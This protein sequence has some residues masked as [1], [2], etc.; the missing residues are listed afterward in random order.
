[1]TETGNIHGCELIG[2]KL[3]NVREAGYDFANIRDGAAARRIRRR[4]DRRANAAARTSAI[5][6]R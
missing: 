1:M 4:E 6:G 5:R 3:G 2:D